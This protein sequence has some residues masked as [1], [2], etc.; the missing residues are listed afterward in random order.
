[1]NVFTYDKLIERGFCGDPDDIDY[2]VLITPISE[3]E[4]KGQMREYA[5]NLPVNTEYCHA[6]FLNS[7]KGKGVLIKSHSYCD[8]IS[9]EENEID[10][11]EIDLKDIYSEEKMSEIIAYRE[12]QARIRREEEKRQREEQKFK[13]EKFKDDKEIKRLESRGYR[14]VKK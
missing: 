12:E 2:Y 13:A 6:D 7:F 11:N 9:G 10:L 8:C 1:M 5:R 4:I 14:V 3:A